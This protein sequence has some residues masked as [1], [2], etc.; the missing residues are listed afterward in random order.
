MLLRVVH[1]VLLLLSQK[2]LLTLLLWA[3]TRIHNPLSPHLMG[4]MSDDEATR[5]GNERAIERETENECGVCGLGL[6]GAG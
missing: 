2:Q 4:S 5:R 6:L 1:K 3:L